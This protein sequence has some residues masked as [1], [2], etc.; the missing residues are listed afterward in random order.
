MLRMDLYDKKDPD[1]TARDTFQP[2]TR[3]NLERLKG[4]P[5]VGCELVPS[6]GDG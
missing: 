4:Q 1:F 5:T 3:E 6:L 2:Q